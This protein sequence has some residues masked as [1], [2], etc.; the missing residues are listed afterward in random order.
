MFQKVRVNTGRTPKPSYCL[1]NS[2][3]TKTTNT[4]EKRTID[5]KKSKT[6]K[7]TLQLTSWEIYLL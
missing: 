5:G 7:N 1:I 2:Q 3:S 4:N 6:T